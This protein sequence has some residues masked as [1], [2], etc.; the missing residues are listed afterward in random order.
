MD[1]ISPDGPRH[2]NN[3]SSK[4]EKSSGKSGKA[5]K[6]HHGEKQIPPS[7]AHSRIVDTP[8]GKRSIYSINSKAS[9]DSGIESDMDSDESESCNDVSSLGVSSG[10]TDVSLGYQ[11]D[12]HSKNNTLRRALSLAEGTIGSH[13]DSR[14]FLSGKGHTQEQQIES[15]S[16]ALMDDLNFHTNQP[17]KQ[18]LHQLLDELKKE[19]FTEDNGHNFALRSAI[20]LASERCG[21]DIDSWKVYTKVRPAHE[22]FWSWIEKPSSWV[23]EAQAAAAKYTETAFIKALSLAKKHPE[24]L[25]MAYKGGFGAGKTS[26]GKE[27]FGTDET[28]SPYFNGS[29]APD[30]AKHAI[31]KSLPVSHH[32]AHIQSS[33]LAFNLF[34]GLIR[35]KGMGT[36]IYDSS[37]SRSSDVVDMIKKSEAAQKPL[38][39]IDVTRDDRARVLAV[40]AREVEGEDPRIPADFLL[41]GASRDRQERPSCFNAIMN[42]RS[43]SVVDNKTGKEKQL[44]HHYDF[45]CGDE[46]GG[47]RQRLFTL[48][49]GNPPIWNI[50]PSQSMDNIQSRLAGQ[51]IS[52]D[53]KAQQFIP[54]NSHENWE[55]VMKKELHKPVK[56][57]VK[58]LSDGERKIREKQFSQRTL[59]FDRPMSDMSIDAFYDALPLSVSQHISLEKTSGSFSVLDSET[60]HNTL[61]ALKACS[62]QFNQPMS[63]MDLPTLFALE[64][65]RSLMS[66]PV[67]W[68]SGSQ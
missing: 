3:V 24:T 42:S 40:L 27:T 28:G 59:F 66:S 45:Y 13:F 55:S 33:N 21:A 53:T 51:G 46:T 29:I 60:R 62:Q 25:V 35:K 1:E 5:I 37:L 41:E 67:H 12:V 65:H 8:L 57:L 20:L 18:A 52:F 23:P 10:V 6:S 16:N 9:S 54:K 47:D 17:V 4:T 32:S 22:S 58:G 68:E 61:K 48:S 11:E 31:R 36:I 19:D 14:M 7:N 15:L 43:F 34:D 56:E 26:H 39:I 44:S 38:K 63:Y 49:S 30:S 64:F 2:I 50:T